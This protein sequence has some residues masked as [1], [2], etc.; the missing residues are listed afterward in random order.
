MKAQVREALAKLRERIAR[1][2]ADKD[3]DPRYRP[4]ETI[5]PKGT[6][7]LHVADSKE[8]DCLLRVIGG[9]KPCEYTGLPVLRLQYVYPKRLPIGFGGKSGKRVVFASIDKLFDPAK[10]GIKVRP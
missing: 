4:N 9:A 3:A 10:F 7:V 6:L 1:I 8:V 5:W 2:E